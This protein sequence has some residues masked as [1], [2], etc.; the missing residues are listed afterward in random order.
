MLS[1]ADSISTSDEENNSTKLAEVEFFVQSSMVQRASQWHQLP[2][3][4]RKERI[5]DGAAVKHAGFEEIWLL[6]SSKKFGMVKIYFRWN[7]I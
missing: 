1:S 3:L 7:D 6:R 5:E 2:Q 4:E